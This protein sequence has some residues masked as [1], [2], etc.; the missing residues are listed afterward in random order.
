M[1]FY[2]VTYGSMSAF[3]EGTVEADN[4]DSA[5]RK[6]AGSAFSRNEM[7]LIKAR[8]ISS[9]EIMKALRRKEED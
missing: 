8:E 1:A 2:K 9:Y 7:P 5:R 6:F 3:Y 4:E